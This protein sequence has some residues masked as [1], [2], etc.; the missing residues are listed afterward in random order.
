MLQIIQTV[1]LLMVASLMTIFLFFLLWFINLQGG[2]EYHRFYAF[3]YYGFVSGNSPEETVTFCPY[4][5]SVV[6]AVIVTI[7][8][9][10]VGF[11]YL[12]IL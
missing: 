7:I 8:A 11:S 1:F 3:F 10:F 5:I 6:L 4:A 12:L 9:F 2:A